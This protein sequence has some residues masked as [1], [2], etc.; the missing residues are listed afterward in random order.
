MCLYIDPEH[1]NP[2]GLRTPVLPAYSWTSPF[3]NALYRHD[4]VATHDSNTILKLAEETTILG[5]ITNDDETAYREE[6]RDLATWCQGNNL[7]MSEMI[8][9][10]RKRQKGRVMPPYTSTELK[11]RKYPP[12]FPWCVHQ[13]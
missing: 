11:W 6:V 13:R 4:C 2:S 10:F 7:S 5:L 3:L 12:S 8:V 1:R 9:D